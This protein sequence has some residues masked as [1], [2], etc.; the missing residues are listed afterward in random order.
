M[1]FRLTRLP[2]ALA[3]AGA[4]V[5]GTLAPAPARADADLQRFLA[6]AAGLVIL[7]GIL[8]ANR[9]ANAA[10]PP[11]RHWQPDPRHG[12]GQPAPHRRPLAL[13]AQCAI[14]VAARGR[15][16]PRNVLYTERCLQRQGVNTARLPQQCRVTLRTDRG[17]RAVYDGA[18]LQ[19]RHDSHRSYGGRPGDW[20]Q[21]HRQR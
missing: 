18:C 6:G 8:D 20:N 16:Q 4:L 1:T 19:Q 9:R 3:A 17:T 11:A 13:P 14:E 2:L 7:Y 10:S 15:G 12:R 21:R 5:L